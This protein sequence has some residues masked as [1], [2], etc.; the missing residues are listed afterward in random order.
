MKLHCKGFILTAVA[1][2]LML[3]AVAQTSTP[4]AKPATINQRKENQQDRIGNGVQS[5]ELTAG[6]AGRLEKKEGEVNQEER[7]MRKLDNGHLTSSDRATL[8][9]QQ[10]KLSKN[11]YN[12]KHDAQT[13]NVNAKSEVGQRERNQQE[14]IA[15]G[16]KS[17]QLTA[18]EA[19]HVEHREAA[20][21][22]EVHNERAAN[23]GTLTP[24]ERR[25]V[26]RQE[27]RTSRAIY[28]KK[29]NGRIQ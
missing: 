7:D 13:Q 29:H 16:V 18:G 12:Q 5:G 20:I 15:Q 26:N 3:P 1:T 6:E 17:G 28:R 14:R 9:Q 19:A 4:A 24:A 10:N 27:N 23:G 8:N 25:Q 11:I 2:G 21:N 22:H